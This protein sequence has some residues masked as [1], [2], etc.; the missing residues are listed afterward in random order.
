MVFLKGWENTRMTQEALK[1]DLSTILSME[2]E[3]KHFEMGQF[4]M[5]NGSKVF[6]QVKEC[7][8]GHQEKS[9]KEKS[10]KV[11]SMEEE[12]KL[13]LMERNTMVILKITRLQDMVVC[14]LNLEVNSSK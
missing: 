14:N 3:P 7:L 8:N 12:S 5:D 10:W 9:T 11:E 1:E 6:P 13:G 4:M 2:L